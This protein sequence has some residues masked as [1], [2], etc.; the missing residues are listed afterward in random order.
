MNFILPEQIS[1]SHEKGNY[2][3]DKKIVVPYVV[4]GCKDGSVQDE[5]VDESEKSYVRVVEVI[6][7]HEVKDKKES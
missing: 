5:H 4:Q 3:N 1:M 2:E 7:E 6:E